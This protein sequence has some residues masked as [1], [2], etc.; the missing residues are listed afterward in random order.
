[1]FRCT[2]C[3]RPSLS[4]TPVKYKN[5][6]F[7]FHDLKVRS[8]LLLDHY[9][10]TLS[11]VLNTEFESE[12][13]VVT[14]ECDERGRRLFGRFCR[15]LTRCRRPAWPH[16]FWIISQKAAPPKF[17]LFSHKNHNEQHNLQSDVCAKIVNTTVVL[18]LELAF[19][20]S[21]KK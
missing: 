12:T 20:R 13:D 11:N 7:N 16:T 2:N 21:T 1:M 9:D 15:E 18:I 17:S 19:S 4:I 8:S 3:D 14:Q 6:S 5:I 10:H